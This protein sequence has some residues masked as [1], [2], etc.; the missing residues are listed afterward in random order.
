VVRIGAALASLGALLTLIAGVGRTT[1]AMARHHD[2][3]RW[4]A[5]VH[6]RHRVPHHAE[7]ALAGVVCILVL[8]SDARDV[9][10]F[11]SFG[12]LI[13]YAIANTAALTQPPADRRW[14][15]TLNLLGIAGCLLLVATLPV[16]PVITGLAVFAIGLAGRALTHHA[17]ADRP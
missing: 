7:L 8:T 5:D 17:R 2:L 1:L 13:Y 6:P 9:I 12:V 16:E 15:R 10:G 11:S 14:P 3:P 4:L